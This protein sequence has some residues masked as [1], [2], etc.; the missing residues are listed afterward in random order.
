MQL[1]QRAGASADRD[2]RGGAGTAARAKRRPTTRLGRGLRRRIGACLA[3]AVSALLLSGARPRQ[4]QPRTLTFFVAS[5]SHFGA[6]GMEASNRSL[7]EQMNALPGTAYPPQIGGHVEEPRGVLFTGDTT[8]NGTL[9]E[10]A[11]FERVYGLDGSDGLLRYPVFEAIGNHDVN[12]E[13]PIKER[14]KRR[15]GGV[16]YSWDWDDLRVVC[17]DMY[18]DAATL[19]WL[20]SELARLDGRRP[21]LL[22]FHYSL[23]GPYSDFWEDHE[24]EALARALE[25]RNVLAIFHGHEHRFG[26]YVWRGQRVFRPGSPRHSSHVFLVVRVGARAMDVAA[27]DFDSRRWRDSWTVPVRR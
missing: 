1:T 5:D 8:D 27:W 7:V 3:L 17:L 16:N 20:A 22:F 14:L 18:P 23:E 26:H 12:S 21:L 11:Q 6:P 4:A 19:R 2:P 13:S 24:K 15:H 10:F 25:G 9:S